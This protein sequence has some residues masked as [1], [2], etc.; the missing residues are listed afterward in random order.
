M[1]V[2]DSITDNLKELL[3][4]SQARV[5][6][7]FD[8]RQL[9]WFVDALVFVNGRCVIR[10]QRDLFEMGEVGGKNGPFCYL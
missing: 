1:G 3:D 2:D 6:W 4:F 10:Q 9:V 7:G 8:V 5:G